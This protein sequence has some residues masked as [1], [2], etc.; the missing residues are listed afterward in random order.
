MNKQIA[1]EVAFIV[2]FAGFAM[3]GVVTTIGWI[4]G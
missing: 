3:I 2:T 1:I 4:W